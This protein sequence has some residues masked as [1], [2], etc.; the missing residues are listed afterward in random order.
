[1]ENPNKVTDKIAG[2]R[3]FLVKSA[4]NLLNQ[5][6]Q[7]LI[8]NQLI[9]GSSLPREAV[10]VTKSWV[11]KL[12]N[13]KTASLFDGWVVL[14]A[15]KDLGELSV[16]ISVDHIS[17]ELLHSSWHDRSLIYKDSHCLDRGEQSFWRG[18]LF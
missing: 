16:I 11:D 8:L 6:N 7:V 3:Q 5:R 15:H 2:A 1:L 17:V 12:S 18:R 4:T 14:A 13:N 10:S 9:V